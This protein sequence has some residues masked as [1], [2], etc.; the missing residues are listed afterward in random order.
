VPVLEIAE[1]VGIVEIKDRDMDAFEGA[2]VANAEKTQGVIAVRSG[3]Q[4]R[5]RRYSQ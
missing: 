3:T 2:L 1:S 4:R 5:R